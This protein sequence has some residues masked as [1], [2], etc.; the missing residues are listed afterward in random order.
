MVAVESQPPKPSS[1]TKSERL[2]NSYSIGTETTFEL[3]LVLCVPATVAR[4]RYKQDVFFFL[5]L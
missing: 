1:A 3:H 4:S 2:E 5:L